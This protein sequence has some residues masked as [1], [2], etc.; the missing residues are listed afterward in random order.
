MAQSYVSKLDLPLS[1]VPISTP[2]EL[3]ASMQEVYNALQAIAGAAQMQV[4]TSRDTAADTDLLDGDNLV[5]VDATSGAVV[6]TLPLAENFIG[7]RFSIKRVNAGGGT[8]SVVPTSPELLD[9]SASAVFLAANAT[10]TVQAGVDFWD[11][12]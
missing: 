3:Y 10:M 9:G 8:V 7:R 4:Y 12:V 11:T 1:Q 2:P 5:R 6:V